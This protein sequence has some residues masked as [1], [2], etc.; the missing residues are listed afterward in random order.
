VALI[1]GSLYVSV[2]LGGGASKKFI[3]IETRHAIAHPN[4]FNE[5]LIKTSVSEAILPVSARLLGNLETSA[6][7]ITEAYY[8][9]GNND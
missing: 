9:D 3:N 4:F 1:T 8:I 2:S 6:S 7:S 5:K